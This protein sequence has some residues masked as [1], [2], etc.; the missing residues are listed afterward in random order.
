VTARFND[1][2]SL[3]SLMTATSLINKTK[4]SWLCPVYHA[5]K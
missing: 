1:L 5:K 2:M 4:L 3:C